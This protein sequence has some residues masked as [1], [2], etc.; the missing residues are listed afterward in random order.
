M[1]RDPVTT[2]TFK[3]FLV[4]RMAM[5]FVSWGSFVPDETWQSVEVAHK[6]VFGSGYL[7]WEWIQGIRSY[8]HPLIFA[9]LFKTLELLRMDF[10][11]TIRLAPRLVQA[12][13]SALGDVAVIQVFK[14]E[15]SPSQLRTFV[16]LYASNWFM[17]Y[18]S[19]RTLVNTFEM[20]L[21]SM[22]LA[23]YVQP[24]QDFRYVGFISLSFIVRPTTAI[25]W[26]PMVLSDLVKTRSLTTFLNKKVKSV[27]LSKN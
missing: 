24:Q 15:F 12:L 6:M 17:L 19:S 13:I 3:Y 16:I 1:F 10:P 2:T 7:T 23:F 11:W 25:F 14:K 27:S 4:L 20:A 21:T 18:A 22:A 9:V 26:I 5:A 8:L